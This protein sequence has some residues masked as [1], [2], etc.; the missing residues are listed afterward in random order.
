[1]ARLSTLDDVG[2]SRTVLVTFAPALAQ[3]G[4][5]WLSLALVG[6]NGPTLVK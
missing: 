2:Q 1:M 3:S 6:N 4:R 5:C